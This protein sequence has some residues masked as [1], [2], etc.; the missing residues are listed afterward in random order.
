MTLRR[1]LVAI[2]VTLVA[3]GLLGST[4]ISY[5][6]FRHSQYSQIDA[7]ARSAAPVLA[8]VMVN[9]NN[10]SF[11]FGPVDGAPGA[12]EP[13]D[14]TAGGGGGSR[15]SDGFGSLP[16][17]SVIELRSASGGILK[18]FS[19]PL[20]GSRNS[21]P[22]P[23]LPASLPAVHNPDGITS[24]VGSTSGSASFRLLLTPVNNPNAAPGDVLIIAVPLTATTSSLHRLLIVDLLVAAGVL[25]ALSA[26]AL[27]I[28]RRGLYPLERMAGTAQVIAK[29]DL[30]R[31][32]SPADDRTEVG[33]LGL[34]LN[35]MLTGIEVAFSERE[36]TEQR[37]RQ[38]LADASH[39]MR[40]P[41]TS[42]R[43]YAEL[44]RL[45]A[46]SS[47]EDLALAM[48]RIEE[49]A[50]RMGVMVEELLLLARLDETRPAQRLPVDLA[51]VAAEACGDVGVA[52]RSHPLRLDAPSPVPVVGDAT[53]LHQAVT[54]LLINATRYTPEGTAIEVRAAVEGG[55]AVLTVRDHGPGLSPE[56]L[57]HAFDRFW[58]ADPARHTGGAGLGLAIVA[59]VAA[60]HG[61]TASV[62]NAADGGAV[63]TIR[64]PI[65][66][67][68]AG[69]IPDD[70]YRAS[71][72]GA[73]IPAGG[74]SASGAGSS[75]AGAPEQPVSPTGSRSGN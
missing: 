65:P 70:P 13:D 17:G 11:H 45:G 47:D 29:G 75:A 10:Y 15:P 69:T 9:T 50:A 38:F 27:L 61:G 53:Y 56:G 73:P 25:L 62:A 7:E 32:V 22:T 64:M 14:G 18:S 46:V 44:W 2:Q 8:Q 41:L 36:A 60:G 23:A 42:I 35:T 72:N 43:G 39:E 5:R 54:N 48:R 51:V 71:K 24:T 66:V 52:R 74:E 68:G 67:P 57:V 21:C 59:A 12:G 28:I 4:L 19:D 6:V 58:Q 55:I 30:S 31:R 40:T 26:G 3:L 37:L 1:K 33:Q 49:Q 20:C 34:A 16:R 63:F